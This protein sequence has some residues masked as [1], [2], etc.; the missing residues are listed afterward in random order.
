ML[1]AAPVNLVDEPFSGVD[2][3]QREVLLPILKEALT[4]PGKL[5]IFVTHSPLEAM[6]LADRIFLMPR[7]ATG[8]SEIPVSSGTD[9]IGA[10]LPASG[11]IRSLYERLLA[12]LDS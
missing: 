5:L 7:H 9:D 1:L 2:E 10:F 11:A 4:G 3:P 12:G 6:F 8:S